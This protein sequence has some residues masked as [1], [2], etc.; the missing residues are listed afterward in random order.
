MAGGWLEAFIPHHA[1]QALVTYEAAIIKFKAS[2]PIITIIA[3]IIITIITTS[4]TT[5]TT[6]TTTTIITM[7]KNIRI[8][9]IIL[10]IINILVRSSSSFSSSVDIIG[11]CVYGCRAAAWIRVL[12]RTKPKSQTHCVK[13]AH[14]TLFLLGLSRLREL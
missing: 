6:T 4:T 13:R 14:Q 8:Y 12:H 10:K 2:F 7:K 1:P 5:A 11:T 9:Y 3:I